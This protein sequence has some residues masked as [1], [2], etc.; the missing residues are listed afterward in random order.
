MPKCEGRSDGPCPTGVCDGT[1]K[2]SQGD[3]MLCPSCDEFWFPVK[4]ERLQETRGRLAHVVT[5]KRMLPV[6]NKDYSVSSV[7]YGSILN[8]MRSPTTYTHS[9]K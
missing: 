8:A 2:L 7:S 3:L 9:C 6:R 5:A 4:K 1:V